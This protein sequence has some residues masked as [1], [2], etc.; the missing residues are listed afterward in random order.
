MYQESKITDQA[1]LLVLVLVLMFNVR[2]ICSFG[3]IH[4]VSFSIPV[5]FTRLVTAADMIE[6]VCHCKL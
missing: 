6:L 3:H 2:P 1:Y 4:S 5:V